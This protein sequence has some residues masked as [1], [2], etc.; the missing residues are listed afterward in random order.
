MSALMAPHFPVKTKRVCASALPVLRQ[1]QARD[2]G[3]APAVTIPMVATEAFRCIKLF[4]LDPSL[5]TVIIDRR[6]STKNGYG[7]SADCIADVIILALVFFRNLD[8][9]VLISLGM[10]ID[11]G[12]VDAIFINLIEIQ[13][14]IIML[15]PS[16]R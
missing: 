3:N 14:F 2:G 4:D 13:A 15:L 12:K 9:F 1:A 5:G 7:I 8:A 11:L 6:D 16:E 10:N